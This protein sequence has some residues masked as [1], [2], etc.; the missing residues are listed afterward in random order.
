M[1]TLYDTWLD[2]IDS[3]YE[4]QYFDTVIEPLCN[5]KGNSVD[6]RKAKGKNFDAGYEVYIYA[7]F[8]GLYYGERTPL[9]GPKAKFRMEMSTWGRKK[10]QQG[11]KN[12]TILQKYVFA[13]LVAKSDVDLIALDKGE[14]ETKEVCDTLM[15]TLCE[16]ANTG[17]AL[18]KSQMDKNADGFLE[19]DGLVKFLRNFCV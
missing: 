5:Y 11:R 15:T 12:Y 8:L 19:S 6:G 7:F 17:F 10:G 2:R 4:E 3:Y 18:M 1:A 16:Y 14:I 9:N 13:A